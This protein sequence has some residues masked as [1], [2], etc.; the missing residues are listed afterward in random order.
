MDIKQVLEYA[1]TPVPLSLCHMDGLMN[2][3]PKATLFKTL[4]SRV[5]DFSPAPSS[6]EAYIVDGFYFLHLCVDLPMQYAKMAR[7]ILQKL[8]RTSAKRIDLIF[9]LFIMPSIKDAERDRR[10]N[11]ERDMLIKILGLNQQR[12]SDWLKALRNDCFKRELSKYLIGAFQD[13]SLSHIIAHRTL[14][15]TF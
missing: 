3:T 6:V 15:V 8:C 10:S 4:E 14:N 13:D 7:H 12:P 1:L 9:D 11:S 5:T 2:K